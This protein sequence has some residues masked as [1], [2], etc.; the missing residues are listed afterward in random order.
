MKYFFL[1]VII[2]IFAAGLAFAS[3]EIF[4]SQES[5]SSPINM[6]EPP[7][8]MSSYDEFNDLKKSQKDFYLENL[9]YALPRIPSLRGKTKEQ[10]NEASEWYQSWNQIRKKVYE[11]CQDQSALKTCEEIADLRLQ[12]LDM[13]SN[14]KKENRKA[15]ASTEKNRER[16]PVRIHDPRPF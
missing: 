2:N 6:A 15:N 9:L 16:I 3:K 4:P 8:W 14:Q 5:D 12:A 7:F 13:F 10:L 1:A 11:F